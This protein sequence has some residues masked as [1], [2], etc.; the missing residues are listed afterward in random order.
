MSSI[1]NVILIFDSLESDD[2]ANKYLSNF[3]NKNSI[4]DIVSIHDPSLPNKWYGGTRYME[5]NVFIGAYNHLDLSEFIDYLK[6]IEWEY[7][8][9]VQLFVREEYVT[10]FVLH[11]IFP[12]SQ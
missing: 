10:G 2:L 1:T 4:L 6:R 5:A 7:P 11:N 3:P 9:S 8:E 12:E